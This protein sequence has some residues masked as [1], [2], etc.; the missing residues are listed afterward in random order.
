MTPRSPATIY[1]HP[2][3]AGIPLLAL[4]LDHKRIGVMY[5]VLDP[6]RLA[7]G[8]GLRH[9]GPR[10]EL[11]HAAAATRPC[12]WRRDIYNQLF[13]LHGAIMVFLFIIP[14]MPAALGN[15]V[16]P[17][18]LGAKDV[19]FPAEPAELLPLVIGAVFFLVALITGGLD[20]GWTFY[21]PYST[22]TNTS[23]VPAVL[24]AFILG[25]SSIFTGLNFIVTDPHA[26]AARA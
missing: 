1:L 11:G 2:R 16:L 24:G 6:L 17:L 22:T 20:T 25:F 18:M 26:A 21:T 15:F 13:T 5:L 12:T 9:A 8:R 10:T 19:A 4:T 14:G 23:V 7:P 3:P